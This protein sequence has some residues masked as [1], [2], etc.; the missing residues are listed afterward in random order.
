M[1]LAMNSLNPF[2]FALRREAQ[3]KKEKN[4]ELHQI[5]LRRQKML[6]YDM[7]ILRAIENSSEEMRKRTSSMCTTI[8]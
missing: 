6:F 7:T 3:K 5:R 1:A 2:D 4:T 8:A